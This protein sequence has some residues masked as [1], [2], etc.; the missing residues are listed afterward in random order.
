MTD[1]RAASLKRSLASALD[2]TLEQLRGIL[3]G[4]AEQG[5]SRERADSV[6]AELRAEAVNESVENRILEQLDLVSGF[7]S[8]HAAIPFVD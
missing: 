5:L 4:Y 7:C 1:E 2:G 6:L 3:I 8:P